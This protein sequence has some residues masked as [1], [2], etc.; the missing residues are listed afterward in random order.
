MD[1]KVGDLLVVFNSGGVLFGGT[2]V[3]AIMKCSS[4]VCCLV[5][6]WVLLGFWFQRYVNVTMESSSASFCL[7]FS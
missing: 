2:A 1:L 3:P 4:T 5:S 7:L 6:F